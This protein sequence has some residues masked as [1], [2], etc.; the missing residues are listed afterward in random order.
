MK[1]NRFLCVVLVVSV[2]SLTG[3]MD[4]RD[5][6]E[7]KA[8]L[9][10]EYAAGVLL[11]YSDTYEHRLIT[12]DQR[13]R[14]DEEQEV[15]ATP[16]APAAT[17]SPEG[18]P[19]SQDAAS[20][21]PEETAEP[22]P[23]VTLDELYQL[24]G[25]KVSYDSCHFAK[26]YGSSQIRAEKGQ[27]LLIVSFSLKNVSGTGK[28]VSLMDR[29]NIRYTLDVDGSQYSPGINILPNGGMDYL[30]TSIGKGKKE[31]AVLIFQMDA[32]KKAASSM[33][34]SIEEGNKK[35]SLKLK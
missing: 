15:T 5:M 22:V 4:V 3:C 6:S 13:K 2:I 31:K 26:K 23:E 1:R 21:T 20:E 35:A 33:T 12:E 14:Q 10:A 25:I 9:V 19:Q 17:D 18:A 34:L 30:K 8:D 28:K 7:E 11:R 27:T 29:R 24:S 16:E 32:G